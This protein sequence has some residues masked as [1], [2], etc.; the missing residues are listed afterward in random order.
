MMIDGV[1]EN[2]VRPTIPF[3]GELIT[4]S[5]P[6]S[7]PARRLWCL[8]MHYAQQGLNTTQSLAH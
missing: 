2:K 3:L 6:E 5:F 4:L 7:T 8:A 1:S